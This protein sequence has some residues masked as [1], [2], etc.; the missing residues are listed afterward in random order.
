MSRKNNAKNSSPVPKAE[1]INRS[2]S[3][4][5]GRKINKKYLD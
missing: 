3:N 1:D 4:V 2:E 5:K